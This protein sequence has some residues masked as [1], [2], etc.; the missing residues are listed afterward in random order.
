MQNLINNPEGAEDL[1][2]KLIMEFRKA[3]IEIEEK[4]EQIE[5]I[6]KMCKVFDIS[7]IRHKL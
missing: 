4:R 2:R 6:E 3:E 5:N 7:D 1:K